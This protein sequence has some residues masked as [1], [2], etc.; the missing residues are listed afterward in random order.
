MRTNKHEKTAAELRCRN[1]RKNFT[2]VRLRRD[3]PFRDH[4]FKQQKEDLL[5]ITEKKASL[6]RY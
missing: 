4:Y 3:T 6:A 5:V 1:L 2:V